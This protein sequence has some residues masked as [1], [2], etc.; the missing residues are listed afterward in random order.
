MADIGAAIAFL[1][2]SRPQIVHG[3]LNDSDIF[4]ERP[5]TPDAAQSYWNLVCRFFGPSIHGR[6]E[7]Q[8]IG[9]LA[10]ILQLRISNTIPIR[11]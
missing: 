9:A 4:V 1:H 11:V 5:A 7:A 8:C 3:N 6:M 2:S 10:A